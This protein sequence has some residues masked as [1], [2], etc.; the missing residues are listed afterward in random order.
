MTSFCSFLVNSGVLECF[1]PPF[2]KLRYLHLSIISD[3][4]EINILFLDSP[5]SFELPTQLADG[6]FSHIQVGMGTYK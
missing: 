4:M 1:L 2:F 6:M 3:E 5:M